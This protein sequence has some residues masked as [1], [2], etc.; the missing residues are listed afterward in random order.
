MEEEN[1]LIARLRTKMPCKKLAQMLSRLSKI[2][3][4]FNIVVYMTNQVIA[5]P[6]GGVFILDPKK[7][8][9]GY[10]LRQ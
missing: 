6:G 7:P 9:G 10:M 2:A 3:E 4:E 5:D 1:L 8:A